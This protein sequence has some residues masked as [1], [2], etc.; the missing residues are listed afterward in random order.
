M[1]DTQTQARIHASE[2][3]LVPRVLVRAMVALV[4]V[5]LSLVTVARLTDRPLES[6]PPDTAILAERVIHLSGDASGAARVLDD[7]GT[8]IASF[9]PD[10]G[11]FV[12]GIDRVL[13]RERTKI[14]ADLS[15]PVLLRLREGNRLSLYDPTTDWSAELMGFG[16]DN[17]RTFARLL[18]PPTPKEA[19]NGT[20]D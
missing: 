14:G 15:A 4:L 10:K 16:A 5:I 6:T 1:S 3:E 9:A 19:T 2:N 13:Q 18:E 7:T 11:G 8:V 20:T 12:A 17:L